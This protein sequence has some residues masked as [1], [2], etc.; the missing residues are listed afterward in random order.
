[1]FN[2]INHKLL[3]NRDH[4]LYKINNLIKLLVNSMFQIMKFKLSK[5]LMKLKNQ[6]MLIRFMKERY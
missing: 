5:K 2:I 3:F 4:K 1:M 6:F